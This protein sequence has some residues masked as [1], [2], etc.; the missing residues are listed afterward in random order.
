MHCQFLLQNFLS[1]ACYYHSTRKTGTGQTSKKY[2]LYVHVFN[3]AVN[4]AQLA[5]LIKPLYSISIIKAIG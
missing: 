4:G 5:E 1:H 3:S 2:H